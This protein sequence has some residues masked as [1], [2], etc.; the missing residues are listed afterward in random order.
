VERAIMKERA[1]IVFGRKK[2]I[3]PL[4][5]IPASAQETTVNNST[6]PKTMT[7]AQDDAVFHAA[8]NK[9]PDSRNCEA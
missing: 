6:E 1:P 3:D 2:P 7:T 8:D 5:A 4:K 9:D